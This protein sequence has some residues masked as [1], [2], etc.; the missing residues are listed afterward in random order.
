ML[1]IN[2]QTHAGIRQQGV[3]VHYGDAGSAEALRHAGVPKAALVISTIPDELLRGTSNEAIVRAIRAVSP[4]VPVFA[5]ASRP[6]T[7]E[8]LYA[9]GAT[10]VYMPSAETANGIFEAGIAALEGNLDSYRDTREAACGPLRTRLD[11]E[12]MST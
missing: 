2:V 10:Y 6:G 7:A 5:C 9:A 11:M 1:D 3:R 8:L 12:G 4:D